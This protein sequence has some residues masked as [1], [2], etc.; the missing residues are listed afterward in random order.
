MRAVSHVD[1]IPFP[2]RLERN[3]LD[4]LFP[5]VFLLLRLH[6]A[7]VVSQTSAMRLERV[8]V[9]VA[10]GAAVGGGTDA[11]GGAVVVGGGGADAADEQGIVVTPPTKNG[12]IQ[13]P[14][15]KR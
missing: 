8:P 7:V 3:H 5:L 15:S 9:D 2:E 13:L 10:V 6:L 1:E 12:S 14:S 4:D 11:V